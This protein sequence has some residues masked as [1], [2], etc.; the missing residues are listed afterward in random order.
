MNPLQQI[1]TRFAPL[2][3]HLQVDPADYLGLIRPAQDTRFGDYQANFAMPLAGKLKRNSREVAAEI[4]SQLDLSGLCDSPEVA[5][6][7]F[8]NLR[9][10]DGW[11]QQQL[12]AALTDPRIGVEP[13][14]EPKT[15][16]ID[17]SSPNVA[18]P[19][20]VGHIR[21]TVIGDSLSKTISFLG[22]RVI[23]D[24][25]LGDW[26]TQFGMIIYGFKH[27]GDRAEY[28]KSPIAHLTGLYRLVRKLVD[29]REALAD[30]PK[31]EKFLQETESKLKQLKAQP[32]PA[33]KREAKE[34]AKEIDKTTAR[35]AEQ[36]EDLAS[37]QKKIAAVEADPR[38]SQLAAEHS[39]IDQAVLEETAKLHAGDADNLKLWQEVLP[40]CREDMQRIYSRLTIRFDHELG[41]SFYH[42][43]LGP[44]VSSLK[45]SGLARES[46]GAICV[47]LD[48]FD[49]PMIVQ[50]R[51][52][53]FLYSTSDLA[54]IEYRVKTW[55]PDV[56]L[57]VV[58]HRQHEH[59]DKLFAAAR[60]WGYK[61]VDL[62]HVS[63]GTVLGDDGKPFKT[64]EGDTVGLESLL[65]E[66]E[67]KAR[68]VLSQLHGEGG[69]QLPENA[70]K[71]AEVIG[72]GALKYADL[73]QNRAS[74]Y[75]FS[76]DKMLELRGNTATYSQ[77]CYARVMGILRNAETTIEALQGQPAPI[78]FT[79]P[80]E[81]TLGLALARFGET[82]EEVTV[83]YRP[84]LLASYL[85]DLTQTFFRF[86]D[87]C[88][89]VQ[90]ATPELKVSRLQLCALT[91]MTIRTG[92]GL[93][94]IEV[95][96]RM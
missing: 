12:Q 32:A 15:Y 80:I 47:F 38:L 24:N 87:Q 13:A 92:L 71:I 37:L 2:L 9:I 89:V 75:K 82:L 43:M 1:R 64:R 55:D 65:D 35:F 48:G 53:A 44:V 63:F 8:I 10:R 46:D 58:D 49:T 95:V 86:Y 33:D 11:L 78:Q 88:S 41:E 76:Y 84:N 67:S 74:D 45:Q 4:V 56:I 21:S 79:E 23:T 61:D 39:R 6:P 22:H 5:G 20:H 66:A 31:T 18:K 73:S 51:D 81:R 42:E 94:G 62:V 69:E 93:L 59:F 3:S 14:K 50:K 91:A 68:T 16:V 96:E 70:G 19:M 54:T 34:L 85:F 17:Y 30:L 26:G 25:H 90:A 27:F 28:Q 7:G 40:Y 52:G 36:R 60:L 57:Y 72:I 77:Y 29:Y 83:D